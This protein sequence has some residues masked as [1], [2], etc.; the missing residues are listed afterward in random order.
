MPAI[1]LIVDKTRNAIDNG[2]IYIAVLRLA[3]D[4]EFLFHNLLFYNANIKSTLMKNWTL[5]R[6]TKWV[7]ELKLIPNAIV[8][9]LNSFRKLRNAIVHHRY[10]AD[11]VSQN[12]NELQ[13]AKKLLIDICNFVEKTEIKISHQN[14]GNESMSSSDDPKW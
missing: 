11:R 9:K 7:T 8:P 6:Y 13:R 12:K 10:Y 4:L 3:A 5:G 14:P 2:D 1:N